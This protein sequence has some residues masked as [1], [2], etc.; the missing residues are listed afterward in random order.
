MTEIISTQPKSRGIED[1]WEAIIKLPLEARYAK[2][3]G[4]KPLSSFIWDRAPDYVE[5]EGTSIAVHQLGPKNGVPMVSFHGNPG[6]ARGPHPTAELLEAENIRLIAF[7]AP[8]FGD[9][10]TVHTDTPFITAGHVASK[11]VE[12]LGYEKVTVMTRS[13]GVPRALGFA[14]LHPKKSLL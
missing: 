3:A 5:F 10:P 6:S 9:S 13:G 7:D 2:M 12:A 14:A 1:P 4:V 11:V 8:G